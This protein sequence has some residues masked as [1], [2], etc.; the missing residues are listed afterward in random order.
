MRTVDMLHRSAVGIAPERTIRE[1]AMLMEQA[2]VGVL[3]VVEGQRLLGVVTDRDLVRR[4]LARGL[5][6]DARVDGVMT[7][8]VVTITADAELE[9]AF[10]VFDTH[11][12]RRLAVTHDDCFVGILSMDDLLVHLTGQLA[13]LTRPV[14]ADPVDAAPVSTE[15]DV[16]EAVT[17]I[18]KGKRHTVAYQPGGIVSLEETAV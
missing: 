14:T 11:G 18:L 13:C 4:A 3:A 1:A 16:P 10:A 12:L 9:S 2:G 15:S 5:G 7:T 17:V 8:P 6:S